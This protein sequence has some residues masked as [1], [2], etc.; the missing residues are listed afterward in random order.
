MPVNL[1]SLV[2][3]FDDLAVKQKLAR[4]IVRW[5]KDAPV[6]RVQFDGLAPAV[7]DS[8]RPASAQQS[9]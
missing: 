1:K 9:Q 5:E 8:S 2:E 4:V 7:G 3:Q 6:G